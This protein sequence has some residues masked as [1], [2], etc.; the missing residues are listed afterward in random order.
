[1]GCQRLLLISGQQRE[2][3]RG[4]GIV[5]THGP[6]QGKA[7]GISEP[8][9]GGWTGAV[10]RE[11]ADQAR[12]AALVMVVDSQHGVAGSGV[13]EPVWPQPLSI[14]PRRC[15]VEGCQHDGEPRGIAVINSGWQF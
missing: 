12:P 3:F 15:G 14:A 1:V 4:E 6:F 2:V 11:Q 13:D 10:S 9:S 7:G 5:A 8:L